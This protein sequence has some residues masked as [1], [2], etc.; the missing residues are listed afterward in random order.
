MIQALIFDLDD[1]LYEET[2]FVRSGFRAVS[3]YISDTCMVD[4]DEVYQMLLEV[5]ANQGRGKVFDVV[6]EKLGLYEK[7]LIPEM[8]KTYRAHEPAISPYPDVKPVL[9]KL[10]AN[11]YKLGLI[12]DGDV[13]AQKN[14]LRALKIGQFFGC[15]IFSDQYGVE[16]RK[17][18]ISPYK[19]VLETLRV[20][21]HESAY[22]GDNPFKDFIGARKL[23]MRAVRIMRGQYKATDVEKQ[24]DADVRIDSLYQVFD[25]LNLVCKST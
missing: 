7:R 18:H 3:R 22:I 10:D 12:T 16:K 17:P 15:A 8:V 2:Q 23:G 24:Q 9:T 5:L 25:V 1:T 19:R 4:R 13:N 21:P 6:L 11:G 14:K 20:L